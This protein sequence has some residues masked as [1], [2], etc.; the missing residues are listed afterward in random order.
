[1]L[2]TVSKTVFSKVPCYF[3]RHLTSY[4]AARQPANTTWQTAQSY[5]HGVIG[6]LRTRFILIEALAVVSLQTMVIAGHTFLVLTHMRATGLCLTSYLT[7]CVQ[8]ALPR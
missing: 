7:C 5:P 2:H 4:Q 6:K 1:M 8:S 3:H